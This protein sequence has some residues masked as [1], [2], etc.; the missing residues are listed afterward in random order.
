[1]ITSDSLDST[2]ALVGVSFRTER[3]DTFSKSLFTALTSLTLSVG[4]S[5]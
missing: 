1:M 4:R 2:V 3:L 5:P